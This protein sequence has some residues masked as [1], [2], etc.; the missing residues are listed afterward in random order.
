MASILG[1]APIFAGPAW[2]EDGTIK[3]VWL[4]WFNAITTEVTDV[5]NEPA[6]ILTL[7][8]NSEGSSPESVIITVL[9]LLSAIIRPDSGNREIQG[10]NE[11]LVGAHRR[12]VESNPLF[13]LSAR[14]IPTITPPQIV[15]TAQAAAAALIPTLPAN[16]FIFVSDYSHW[17]FW[18]GA[19]S[20]FAD[21]GSDYYVLGQRASGSVGWHAVDGT[22]NVPYLNADGTVSTRTLTNVAAVKA[23]LAGGSGADTLNAPVAPTISGHTEVASTGITVSPAAASTAGV[24]TADNTGASSVAVLVP[25][26]TGGGGGGAVTDPQH[27]H[28]LL[29]VNAPISTTGEPRNFYSVLWYRR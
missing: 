26:F 13:L 16:T 28:T 1:R 19:T 27:S 11:R 24:G 12:E 5:I 18:N 22:A 25:P 14:P 10:I 21:D 23:Y 2:N 3:E 6:P 20:A 8:R 29:A 9:G 7:L 4:R 17:L 15:I